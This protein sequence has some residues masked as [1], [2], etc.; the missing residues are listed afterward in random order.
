[1]VLSKRVHP[2]GGTTAAEM[3]ELQPMKFVRFDEKYSMGSQPYWNEAAGEDRKAFRAKRIKM[4]EK[5]H[6]G[7]DP[8][9]WAVEHAA[10]SFLEL[11]GYK[12]LGGADC[13]PTAWHSSY[14]FDG[15]KEG[16][17]AWGTEAVE[18]RQEPWTASLEETAATIRKAGKLFGADEVGFCHLDRNW[19]FNNYYDTETRTEHPIKFSDE[20][21]YEQYNEPTH[22]EDGTFVIP[23]EA[24]NVV[25]L[26]HEWPGGP[27]AAEFAPTLLTHSVSVA[28]YSKFVPTLWMT[29][30]FIRSLGYY[31][32]PC[33]NDIALTIP[34]AVDAG[35]GQVGRHSSLINP[36]YGSRCRISKIFTN[37][38][39]PHDGAKDFGITEFCDVCDKCGLKCGGKAIP[40]GPR[41]FEA[42][43]ECNVTGINLWMVD[44]KKCFDYQNRVGSTCSICTRMCPWTKGHNWVHPTTRWF[45]MH[46]RWDWLNKFWVWLDDVLGYGG[47]KNSPALYWFREQ[48]TTRWVLGLLRAAPGRARYRI[49]MRKRQMP[50]KPA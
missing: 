28:A 19:V 23:K 24:S 26:L 33:G 41:S 12:K 9:A 48:S 18:E 13:G 49:G 39:L 31:A 14:A 17:P 38:P 21:G 15:A 10:D 50:P 22:L 5:G 4:A 36:K 35:L 11:V 3:Y 42:V 2:Q 16:L 37:M 46:C 40:T 25:V 44:A 45:I 20:P 32:I 30:E 6:P 47:Y 8:L 29:A 7:Y 43:N 34:L 27:A 1:M